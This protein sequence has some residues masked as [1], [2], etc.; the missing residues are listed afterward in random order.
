[1][2]KEDID[3][4]PGELLRKKLVIFQREIAEL[5]Q[6]T[7]EQQEA[8][9]RR[10]NE[11]IMELLEVLDIFDALEKNLGKKKEPLDRTSLALV[12]NLRAVHRKLLRLLGS[13]QILPLDLAGRKARMDI[14]RILETR[15]DPSRK[16]EEILSVEK[17]G[18]FDAERNL[19]LR[20]ADV[21]TVCNDK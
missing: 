14:C 8:S 9:L 13:R 2:K 21:V 17:K 3:N 1:M 4:N 15:H 7:R 18:Y 19:V 11:L 6:K 20:K 12:N 5:R 10:E 16:N